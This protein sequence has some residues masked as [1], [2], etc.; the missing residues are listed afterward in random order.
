MLNIYTARTIHNFLKDKPTII[1]SNSEI[2]EEEIRE[3]V[4]CQKQGHLVLIPFESI[5][6]IKFALKGKEF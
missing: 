6:E 3:W 5:N 4:L 1:I 2:T